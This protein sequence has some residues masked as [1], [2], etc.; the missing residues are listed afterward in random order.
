MAGMRP[1]P[2]IA[3]AVIAVTWSGCLPCEPGFVRGEEGACV[4][5][6]DED[7][8]LDGFTPAEGDCDDTSAEIHPGAVEVENAVDDNCDGRIDEGTAAFDDDGDGFSEQDGDCDDT[9]SE[10]G[11]DADEIPNDGIDNDCDPSTLDCVY[12][13]DPAWSAGEDAR[14][15]GAVEAHNEARY[16]AGVAPLV[17]DQAL[18][19]VAQA[20]SET[21][22]SQCRWEHSGNGYGENLYAT[23]LT[24]AWVPASDPVQSW[25]DERFDY[26]YPSNTCDS[27]KVC[28]HYTQIVWDST[29]KVGC[30]AAISTACQLFPEWPV[31]VQIWTCTYDPPG[32]WVGQ[33]PYPAIEAACVDLDNDRAAQHEDVDDLDRSRQ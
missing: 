10:V 3:L 33:K 5:R 13:H 11:P 22:V 14:N 4:D 6:P 32:N 8:D 23:T 30:G 26:D 12:V 7:T 28:G 16:L 21:L 17:W 27:G 20:Y 31:G 24:Q 19:D 25:V 2:A 15:A 9:T 29:T 18:A 1:H